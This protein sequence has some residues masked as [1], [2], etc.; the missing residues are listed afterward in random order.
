MAVNLCNHMGR[1]TL[2]VVTVIH[3]QVEKAAYSRAHPYGAYSSRADVTEAER[4]LSEV[5]D[6]IRAQLTNPE[7]KVYEQLLE[8]DSPAK[9]IVEEAEATG[10]CGMIILGAR[11]LGGF[12]SLALGSVSS[13]VLHAARCPVLI[14]KE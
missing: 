5:G 14:I 3:P 8:H 11:G 4:L 9:A 12:E 13:Q 7:A 6:R 10:E 2:E 1:C